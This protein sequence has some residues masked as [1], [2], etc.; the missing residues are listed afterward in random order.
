MGRETGRRRIAVTGG[1][2]F[3]GRHVA[4]RLRSAGHEV[5]VLSRRSGVDLTGTNPAALHEALVGCDAVIHCAG[6]N[7][8]LGC[9]TYDAV[10]VRGTEALVVAARAA[11]VGH[12]S[13]LSFLRARPDGPTAYH[14]SKWAA[15]AIV[16]SSGIPYTVLKAGVIY[17][18]GDHLLDHLSRALSTVPVFGLVGMR[19]RPIRPVAVDDVAR[20]LE[21]AALGDLRLVNR[22]LAIVGPEEL[23]LRDVVRRVASIIGRRPLVVRLPVVALRALATVCEVAMVVPL[24]SI[25][26]VRILAEGV[27]DASPPAE[28]PP[29][30]L[31]PATA[32]T[33]AS[34]RAG[35]PEPR[36]FGCGDL[37][38]C[39]P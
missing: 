30:D 33:D 16:R 26:Q 4:A 29:S 17:G 37:R 9:Q 14:R 10:H 7:R 27:V 11:D 5:I 23:P 35:L 39:R 32:F 22:T 12:I 15:E 1:T 19:E 31:A 18:R 21:A 6:I 2:G 24:I 28:A 13:V 20:I 25:A 34:I 38:W 36:R 8:E 3:V